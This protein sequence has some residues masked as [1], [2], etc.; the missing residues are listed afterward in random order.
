MS[1]D[2][3]AP[4]AIALRAEHDALAEK[5]SF[6]RSVD[7][8]RSGAYVGF[9]ALIGIGL[10]VKL[11]WDR[12]GPPRPGVVRKIPHGPPLFFILAVVATV[13]VALVAAR[14]FRRAATLRREEDALFARMRAL[15]EAM[16]LEG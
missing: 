5:L 7:H 12:W 3:A 1:N 15:R 8:V 9:A 4:N 14:A 11:A 2:P 6:R 16:E 13:V 10:S